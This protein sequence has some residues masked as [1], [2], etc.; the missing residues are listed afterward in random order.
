MAGEAAAMF[1]RWKH[2]LGPEITCSELL[3]FLVVLLL[4]FRFAA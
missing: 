4:L 2:Q 3:A 1:S